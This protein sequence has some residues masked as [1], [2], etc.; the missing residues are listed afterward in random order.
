MNKSTFSKGSILCLKD[1]LVLN[2]T[3]YVNTD[4]NLHRVIWFIYQG[5]KIFNR[6][7]SVIVIHVS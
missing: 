6:W 1:R 5:T 3:A 4:F 7:Y 2:V